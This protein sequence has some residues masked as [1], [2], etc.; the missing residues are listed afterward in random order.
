MYRD[1]QLFLICCK[2]LGFIPLQNIFSSDCIRWR[3]RTYNFQTLFYAALKFCVSVV[4]ILNFSKRTALI[5]YYALYL[6]CVI[7]DALYLMGL[8]KL[9]KCVVLVQKFENLRIASVTPNKAKYIWSGW[10]VFITLHSFCMRYLVRDTSGWV[11]ITQCLLFIL[12]VFPLLA[13]PIC[14]IMVCTELARRFYALRQ[15]CAFVGSVTAMHGQHVFTFSAPNSYVRTMESVRTAY[16]LL[17]QS[18]KEFLYAYDLP[19]AFYFLMVLM[20]AFYCCYL[21]IVLND[22]LN[23]HHIVRFVYHCS[24]IYIVTE[25]MDYLKE[26]VS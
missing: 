13:L 2:V 19:I 26:S 16:A 3:I 4:Y 1:L 25:R 11:L 14:F 23:F 18:A 22:T 8:Q 12:I 9:V 20:D 6:S 7:C 15:T 5:P 17:C 10:I 21:I 24:M